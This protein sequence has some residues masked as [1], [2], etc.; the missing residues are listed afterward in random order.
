MKFQGQFEFLGQF[1]LRFIHALFF[2]KS[3]RIILKYGYANFKLVV[4][5]KP[6]PFLTL[7]LCYEFSHSGTHYQIMKSL[8]NSKPN[9]PLG[10][11]SEGEASLESSFSFLRLSLLQF[12]WGWG[13]TVC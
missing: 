7:I 3:M 12:L 9:P 6:K 5:L 1:A 11:S 4:P 13:S 2:P 10:T 8:F